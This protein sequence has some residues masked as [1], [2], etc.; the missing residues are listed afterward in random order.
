MDDGL[1]GLRTLAQYREGGR[2]HIFPSETSL[3]WT[4]RKHR[5]EL[6]REGALL[7]VSGRRM[8]NPPVFDAVVLAAARR[9]MAAQVTDE[10]GAP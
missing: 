7:L 6:I 3:E 5:A 2:E 8:V 9:A 10:E 1:T 4:C